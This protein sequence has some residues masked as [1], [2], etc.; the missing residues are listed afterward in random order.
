MFGRIADKGKNLRNM[1]IG[2]ILV[3]IGMGLLARYPSA[4]ILIPVGII[5]GTADSLLYSTSQYV[6]G[7]Y[8]ADHENDGAYIWARDLTE[9]IGRMT[10]PL[11]W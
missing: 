6:L 8:N 3:L 10:M 4:S 1:S 2:W 11:M 5:V 9:N 7:I